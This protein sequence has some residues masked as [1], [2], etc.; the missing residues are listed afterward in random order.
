MEQKRGTRSA[1]SKLNGICGILARQMNLSELGIH[2][3]QVCT[4][5]ASEVKRWTQIAED[6]LNHFQI[7]RGLPKKQQDFILPVEVGFGSV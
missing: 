2:P 1:G 6:A 4:I 3:S 7:K 5:L